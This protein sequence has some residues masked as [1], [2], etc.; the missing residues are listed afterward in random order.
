MINFIFINLY[1]ESNNIYLK[2]KKSLF[3]IC[4]DETEIK[5]NAL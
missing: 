3:W 5:K 2:N 1:S 4:V